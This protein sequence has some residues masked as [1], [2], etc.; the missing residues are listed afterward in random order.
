MT[1]PYGGA[2]PVRGPHT[3]ETQNKGEAR[4]RLVVSVLFSQSQTPDQRSVTLEILVFQII[5][6]I[7]PLPHHLQKTPSRMMI[8]L[9]NLQVLVQIVDPVGQDGY[10][11]LGRTRVPLLCLVIVDDLSFLFLIDHLLSPF[12]N[13]PPAVYRVGESQNTARGIKNR[14]RQSRPQGPRPRGRLNHVLIINGIF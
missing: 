14:R 2:Y 5:Q 7:S 12:P 4:P 11:H 3:R 13:K 9:V 10:L 8:L 1:P 6:Q